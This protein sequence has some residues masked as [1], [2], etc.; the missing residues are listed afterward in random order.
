MNKTL[1]RLLA[2]ASVTVG[3][4]APAQAAVLTFDDVAKGTLTTYGGFNWTNSF[5]DVPANYNGLDHVLDLASSGQV[6]INP[7]FG[8]SSIASDTVFSLNSGYF[9]SWNG[10]G[11]QLTV[12]AYLGGFVQGFRTYDIFDTKSTLIDFDVSV[13]G[14]V[15]KVEFTNYGGVGTFGNSLAIN[16]LR[17]NDAATGDVP[18]PASIAL[19][20]LGLLGLGAARRKRG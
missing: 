7:T 14:A 11:V 18:E 12:T 20:G 4:L 10:S 17:V 16:D 6:L 9:T 5:V 13:F 8:I 19:L 2:A 1:L 3:L 15:D